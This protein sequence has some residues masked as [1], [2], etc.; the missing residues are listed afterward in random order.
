MKRSALNEFF[1]KLNEIFQKLNEIFRKLNEFFRKLNEIFQKLNE[2]FRKPSETARSFF[3]C[4]SC[5]SYAEVTHDMGSLPDS[6]VR[7]MRIIV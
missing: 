6:R 3:T 1:R 4:T 5:T 7:N 2:I